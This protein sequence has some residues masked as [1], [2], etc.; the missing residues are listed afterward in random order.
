MKKVAVTTIALTIFFILASF[1][2][3][4]NEFQVKGIVTNI[5]GNQITIKDDK[6]KETTIE[7]SLTDIKSVPKFPIFILKGE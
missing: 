3:A 2:F 1:S 4:E 6:G 7:V 5:N